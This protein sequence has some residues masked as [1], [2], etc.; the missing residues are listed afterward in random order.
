MAD[1]NLLPIR[2][3]WFLWFALHLVV[4]AYMAPIVAEIFPERGS[5]FSNPLLLILSI[6]GLVSGTV[7]FRDP[8]RTHSQN[9]SRRPGMTV[10][11]TAG[12]LGRFAFAV[13]LSP[14]IYGLL[15][16]ILTGQNNY[17]IF[18]GVAVLG[19]IAY[20]QLLGS[21]LRALAEPKGKN[22]RTRR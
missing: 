14:L 6:L 17:P 20:W 11:D 7:I 3:K 12:T 2:K 1:T 9:L 15:A 13:M 16:V 5:A 19:A 4:F 8:V 21:A 10:R 18:L 22:K